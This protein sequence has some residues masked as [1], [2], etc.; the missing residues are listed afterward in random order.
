[1][2]ELTKVRLS[3][4]V[5]NSW[6]KEGQRLPR[7]SLSQS[8]QSFSGILDHVAFLALTQFAVL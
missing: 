7:S 3:I 6:E 5:H 1:M 8:L 4:D 2:D